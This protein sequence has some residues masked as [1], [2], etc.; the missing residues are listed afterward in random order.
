MLPLLLPPLVAAPQARVDVGLPS[1]G[2]TD[3]G[4]AFTEGVCRCSDCTI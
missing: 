3:G 4:M 2:N 1:S